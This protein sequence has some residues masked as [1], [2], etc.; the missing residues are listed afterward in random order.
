MAGPKATNVTYVEHGRVRSIATVGD[1]GAYLI[2]L[3][4]PGRGQ[5][6]FSPLPGAGGGPIRS[7]AF[8]NGYVCHLP[9]PTAIGG[10]QTCPHIG[11]VPRAGPAPTP[12]NVISPVRASIAKSARGHTLVVSFIARL[13]VTS[14]SA[15][16][17]V[18]VEFPGREPHC[19]YTVIGPL[20]SNVARGQR[21]RYTQSTNGCHGAF[22]GTVSYDYGRNGVAPSLG[23]AG[24]TVTVG[25]FTVADP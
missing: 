2:V 25:T 17:T 15:Q 6:E 5:Q 1:L 23:T 24:H 8:R 11:Q 4:A 21:E 20:L 14:A 19:G 10:A 16:Y 9:A 22:R 13:P 3:P 12:G 18:R 7:I